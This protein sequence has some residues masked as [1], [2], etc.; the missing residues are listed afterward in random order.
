[1]NGRG[2]RVDDDEADLR[3]QRDMVSWLPLSI[4]S[5]STT[6]ARMRLDVIRNVIERC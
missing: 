6:Y 2:E 3:M 5:E 1:M 4:R